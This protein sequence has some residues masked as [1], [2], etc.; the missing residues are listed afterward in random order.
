M[1]S[2][3]PKIPIEIATKLS[4]SWRSSRP[5]VKRSAPEL[6]SVP[7]RPTR[8]PRSVMQNALMSEPFA[9]TIAPTRP[10]TM[11][12]KYSAGWNLNAT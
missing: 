6:M 4:P 12:L 10:S 3:Y 5:N 8:S 11:R 1:I 9:R 7:M 2:A